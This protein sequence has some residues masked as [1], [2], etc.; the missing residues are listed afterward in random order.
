MDKISLINILNSFNNLAKANLRKDEHLTPVGFIFS[1][2]EDLRIVE[3][4]F[5]T[6]EIKRK[7]MEEFWKLAKSLDTFATIILAEAWTSE[8]PN[9]TVEIKPLVSGKEAITMFI[10][11]EN[12]KELWVT[13]FNRNPFIFFETEIFTGM[14]IEL[15]ETGMFTTN[16][17]ET[18]KNGYLC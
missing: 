10:S 14:Q 8:L 9:E 2:S 6:P 18:S 13:P 4:T 5:D 3:F 16:I 1:K 15:L 11:I 12:E 17:R 7:E